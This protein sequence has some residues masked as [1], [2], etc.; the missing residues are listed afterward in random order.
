MFPVGAN[1]T[2]TESGYVVG[3]TYLL[4][5]GGAPI[6]WPEVG[7][8]GVHDGGTYPVVAAD[9][10]FVLGHP[11]RALLLFTDGLLRRLAALDGSPAPVTSSYISQTARR[12]DTL[13]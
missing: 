3:A 11:A 2:A 8:H 7:P 4:D 1:D 6:E 9:G 13:T 12:I 10:G 5:A